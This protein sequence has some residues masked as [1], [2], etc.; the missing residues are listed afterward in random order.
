MR[1]P[2]PVKKGESSLLSTLASL[3]TKHQSSLMVFIVNELVTIYPNEVSRRLDLTFYIL[4]HAK[5]FERPQFVATFVS[6]V[7]RT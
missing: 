6:E 7:L 1:Q 5:I 3:A 2:P 4:W